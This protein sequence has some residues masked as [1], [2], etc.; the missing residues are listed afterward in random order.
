MLHFPGT[1]FR[2]AVGDIWGF[3]TARGHVWGLSPPF[4]T[5]SCGPARH[6]SDEADEGVSGGAWQPI[7]PTTD[8]VETE[9]VRG[10]ASL[11][12]KRACRESGLA[13]VGEP[14]CA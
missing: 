1:F 10:A 8:H 5:R 3:P 4:A 14:P 9:N 6:V 13:E 11:S 7:D 2:G 12:R